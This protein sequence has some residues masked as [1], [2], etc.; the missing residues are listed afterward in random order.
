LVATILATPAASGRAKVSVILLRLR[1]PSPT[2][3]LQRSLGLKEAGDALA[4][5]AVVIVAEDRIRVRTL[6][7][8]P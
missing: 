4:A 6:P 7:I 3:S 5:G 8:G 2:Y 1:D